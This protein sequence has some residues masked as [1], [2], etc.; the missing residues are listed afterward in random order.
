MRDPMK[1]VIVLI[2]GIG[3]SV[4]QRDGRDVWALSAGAALRGVL[5]LGGSIKRLQLDG[6]DPEA[7]DLGD[8]IRATRLM[9]D[10][11]VLPG[12]DWK[13]DGYGHV[14][15]VI[16]E[17]FDCRPGRNY[18][19]LPY[20]WR[21]D[22]RV[23]ARALAR[24]A[25]VWLREWRAQSGNDDAKLVLIGH[26]MGGLVARLFLETLDGWKQTKT[27]ITFG[28]P[29]AGSLNA[30]RFLAEGFRKGWGPLSIDL[31]DMLRS[32][33]SV[34]QL[35]PSYRCL[36]SAAGSWGYL[37]EVP[38]TSP[39]DD[40]RVKAAIALQRSLRAAVDARLQRGEPGYVV[41]PIVGDFQRSGWAARIEGGNVRILQSR[42]PDEWGGDGTVPTVSAMPHELLAEASNATFVSQQHA[43][44]QND[45]PV[46]THVAGLLR[47]EAIGR[48]VPVFP[49]GDDRVSLEIDDVDTTEPLVVRARPED[50]RHRLTATLEDA[51]DGSSRTVALQP[52]ADGWQQAM[53]EGLAA[54]DYRVTVT[55][56][57]TR[58]VTGVASVVDLAELQHLDRVP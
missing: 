54:S 46:L 23:A 20:D 30:L 35:L 55:A 24:S 37:D 9:P 13:I 14:R 8:G 50:P 57:G 33:T 15:D 48:A 1:D 17:R 19:E 2:P 27:L 11:H 36:E 49:A 43:S 51:R 32:F 18:F 38:W 40:G 44:L 52:G 34:Y 22:N 5:S 12:L 6:D 16:M 45:G 58:A 53:V 29:Y 31:S 41:R 42:G 25:H 3:G 47:S 39:I 4:L 7:D 10:L 21:R 56:P 28:T 26:S